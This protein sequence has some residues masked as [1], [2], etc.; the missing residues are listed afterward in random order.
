MREPISGP[1]AWTAQS[2]AESTEWIYR[3]FRRRGG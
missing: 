1:T 2:I 3:F